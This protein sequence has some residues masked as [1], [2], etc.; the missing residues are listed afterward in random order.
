MGASDVN[1]SLTTPTTYYSALKQL[2]GNFNLLARQIGMDDRNWNKQSPLDGS[3]VDSNNE[4]QL[5]FK[6]PGAARNVKGSQ[7]VLPLGRSETCQLVSTTSSQVTLMTAEASEIGLGTMVMEIELPSGATN[8]AFNSQK[9]EIT[10]DFELQVTN[11]TKPELQFE[12]DHKSALMGALAKNYSNP[13]FTYMWAARAVAR[14]T[15]DQVLSNYRVRFRVAD[16]G[17]WGSWQ[18]SAKVYPG[19]T[20]VD[21]FFPIFD[22]EKVMSLNGSRPAVIEVEHEYQDA[23]GRKVQESDSFPVQMLSRNEVVFSS[24]KSEEITGFADQFDF[25]PALMTSMTTPADPVVQQLAGRI[26]GMAAE[27]YGRSI[28]ASQ[29]DDE[30]VAF[31]AATFHFLK[32]NQIAYQS[33]PGMLTQGRHGQHIK[34]TRDVLRN[35]AGTCIDLAVTWASVCEAVGLEPAIVVIPGHAFPAV[36]LPVSKRWVAIEST[37][38]NSTFKEAVDRGMTTLEE[39]QKGDHY[40]IDIIET[41]TAGFLGLDLPDVPEDYLSNL[42][43]SFVAQK[44]EASAVEPETNIEAGTKNSEQNTTEKTD[45]NSNASLPMETATVQKMNLYASKDGG[46]QIRLPDEP[47]EIQVNVGQTNTLQHRWEVKG[48]EVHH[49]VAWQVDP[50]VKSDSDAILELFLEAAKQAML[51]QSNGVI[52]DSKVVKHEEGH[53]SLHFRMTV[54]KTGEEVQCRIDICGTHCYFI[55][56]KGASEFVNGK[57]ATDVLDSFEVISST[58]SP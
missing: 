36:K 20:V 26:N 38:L 7:W 13:D 22:L 25:A 44:F 18:R 16:M 3:F 58:T 4:I 52:I 35:R 21:P 32:S 12:V 29:T 57:Q 39:A 54:P 6:T 43:Y 10:Y 45:D 47:K 33:P 5:K 56:A 31:M 50:K 17:S 53:L 14:N 46:F 42:G 49:L 41:R 28:A 11:G 40:L 37:M 48:P 19:Q 24:L 23:E 30:C 55:V 15:G 27:S 1:V 9:Q 51:E 34:Y 8:A 2:G